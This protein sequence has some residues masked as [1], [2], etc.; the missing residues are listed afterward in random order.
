MPPTDQPQWTTPEEHMSEAGEYLAI[1]TNYL[2]DPDGKTCAWDEHTERY[3]NIATRMAQIHLHSASTKALLQGRADVEPVDLKRLL[4]A[5]VKAEGTTTGYPL[6]NPIDL[7]DATFV[8]ENLKRQVRL[9]LN[10]E[11]KARLPIPGGYHEYR[12]A[13]KDAAHEWA[14]E[15]A[16]DVQ[17]GIEYEQPGAEPYFNAS[18]VSPDPF[19]DTN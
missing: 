13:M 12:N 9:D 7:K 6:F 2:F 15:N 11:G 19:E 18:A 8:K 4:R 10:A 14:E 17:T 16:V 3:V 1:A 5:D